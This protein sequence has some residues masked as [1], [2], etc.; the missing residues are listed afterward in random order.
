MSPHVVA[1]AIALLVA[2][3]PRADGGYV[4][5]QRHVTDDRG[6]ASRPSDPGAALASAIAAGEPIAIIRAAAH[7]DALTDADRAAVWAAIDR[8]DLDALAAA[9]AA[10]PADREPAGAVR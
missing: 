8:A 4:I 9:A 2:C 1:T 3:G 6:A 7:V 10:L 5:D